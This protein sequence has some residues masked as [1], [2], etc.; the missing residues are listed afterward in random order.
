MDTHEYYLSPEIYF[1]E[2]NA[3]GAFSASSWDGMEDP[4]IVPPV[5]WD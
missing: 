3:E 4:G 2:Y 1:V 5:N